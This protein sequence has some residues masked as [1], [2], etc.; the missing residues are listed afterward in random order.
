MI[1]MADNLNH[2]C[3]DVTNEIMSLV[4]HPEGD[5]SL[6]YYRIS[7]YMV[8]YSEAFKANGWKKSEI[9]KYH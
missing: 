7:K 6:S 8:D 9:Q 4:M 5:K 2:N 1:P 3:I